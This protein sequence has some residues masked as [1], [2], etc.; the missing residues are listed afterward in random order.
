M[1]V[2][3]NE[4][5]KKEDKQAQRQAELNKKAIYLGNMANKVVDAIEDIFNNSNPLPKGNDMI[6]VMSLATVFVFARQIGM[7]C[8]GRKA[9]KSVMKSTAWV[10][11]NQIESYS[12]PLINTDEAWDDLLEGR[13]ESD[14]SN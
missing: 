14:G 2:V 13:E 4:K 12:E 10:L 9:M 3:M 6:D 8:K 11:K 1:I 5:N 7:S